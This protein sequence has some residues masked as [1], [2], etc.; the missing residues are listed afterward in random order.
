[1]HTLYKFQRIFLMKELHAINEALNNDDLD[2]C[3][4]L[5]E[6]L[7]IKKPS[8]SL[9][10]QLALLHRKRG[11]LKKCSHFFK[12]ALSFDRKNAAIYMAMALLCEPIM[13]SNEIIETSRSQMLHQLQ[14]LQKNAKKL[15]IKKPEDIYYLNFYSAYHGKNEAKVN[16][17]MMSIISGIEPRLLFEAAHT[18]ETPKKKNRIKIG[19]LSTYLRHHTIGRLF[20]SLLM[21]LSDEY[22][23]KILI[24]TREDCDD[25]TLELIQHC[26]DFL[27]INRDV[28]LSQIQIQKQELDILFY[29]E[30][31]MDG[32]VH[33]LSLSRLAHIQIVTW[34]HPITTGSPNIDF[35]LLPEGMIS[36]T[37][38]FREN[39]LSVPTPNI[40][41]KKV[42][43]SVPNLYAETYGLP[44][45]NLYACP[46][47]LYKFHPDYIAVFSGILERDPNAVFVLSRASGIY[48]SNQLLDLWKKHI[49]NIEKHIYWMPKI[50]RQEFI[51][52]LSV[53][54][55]MIDPFPFGGGNTVLEALSVDLPVVTLP[56]EYARCRIAQTL[57]QTMNY[58]ELI[59]QNMEEYIELAV[60]VATDQSGIYK[61]HIKKCKHVLYENEQFVVDVQNSILK[62]WNNL[63]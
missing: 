53:C 62:V 36:D 22:F 27:Y 16:S 9:Y 17:K 13:T 24:T 20:S 49:P 55:V 11:D 5:L 28:Y 12:L 33:M 32:F 58:K 52:L 2:T 14:I 6:S 4:S 63:E 26:S 10:T 25:L 1:M 18:T 37:E 19:F 48:W 38:N 57:Y 3:A 59:A 40:Y 21:K 31:G 54:Q 8:L 30:I 41:Y 23:E 34:G 44:K 51:D 60:Q 61:D 56:T 45:G 39:I 15:N 43:A 35:F 50:P 7:C 46:Q 29:P 42:N 47:T